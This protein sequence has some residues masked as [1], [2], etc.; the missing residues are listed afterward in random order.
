MNRR[1]FLRKTSLSVGA[2]CAAGQSIQ[3]AQALVELNEANTRYT[4]P[5]TISTASPRTYSGS[6]TWRNGYLD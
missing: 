2:V 6:V 1:D 5:P 4:K 3:N